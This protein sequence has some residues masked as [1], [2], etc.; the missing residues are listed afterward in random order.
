MCNK[1][2]STVKY[3]LLPSKC[4]VCHSRTCKRKQHRAL[5]NLL[6]SQWDLFF[7]CKLSLDVEKLKL[8][9]IRHQLCH[10]DLRIMQD[11]DLERI[12]CSWKINC[13]TSKGKKYQYWIKICDFR[14]SAQK[15]RSNPLF[16]SK[17]DL[18]P[19]F[20]ISVHG[21]PS[22]HTPRLSSIPS[23]SPSV[24]VYTLCQKKPPKFLLQV[25]PSFTSCCHI[26][27]IYF[28]SGLSK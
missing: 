18:L 28:N 3:N 20:L 16:S 6:S 13:E 26:L 27:Q 2:S 8:K 12:V 10:N 21:T 4:N 24:L 23:L 25:S 5:W 7:L 22:P 17:P 14:V 19:A 1:L 15:R 11:D 9:M